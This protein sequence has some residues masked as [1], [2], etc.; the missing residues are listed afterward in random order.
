MANSLYKYFPDDDDKLE[1]FVN[2]S[3]YLTPPK[4]FNDPWDF[5]LR[6]EPPTEEMVEKEVGH[7]LSPEDPREFYKAE[8]SRPHYLEDE[9][10]EQRDGSSKLVG[11]ICLTEDP[12]NRLM[13]A[14]YANSHKGF[15]AEFRCGEVGLFDREGQSFPIC[16][17]PFG[18]AAAVKVQY[19]PELPD[20]KRGGANLYD[21]VRMK[22]ITWKYENEWRAF[23]SLK[24][25][26]PHPNKAGFHL[27]WFKPVNLLR[28]IIGLQA[29][30]NVK[31]QLRQMLNHDQYSH[32][33]K[34]EA[35]INPETRN[36]DTRP[37]P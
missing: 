16:G 6:S 10:G 23:E 29:S 35:F 9:A 24:K 19:L 21:V 17:S 3:V 11:I 4:H 37:L 13:W 36:L 15:V 18:G 5:R 30:D 8:A 14:N 33:V 31:F 22:H 2:G 26:T 20:M 1:R 25:A 32:V 7:L 28:V 34:E 27:L 12:L